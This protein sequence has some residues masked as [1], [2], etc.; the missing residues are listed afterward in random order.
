MMLASRMGV[1]PVDA[2]QGSARHGLTRHG[3]VRQGMARA[4]LSTELLRGLPAGFFGIQLWRG[5]AWLGTGRCG[6]VK[7][8]M[9]WLGEAW[10]GEGQTMARSFYGG[11][12]PPFGGYGAARQCKARQ[13]G[14][15]PGNA[16][17][18]KG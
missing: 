8:G 3:T 16:W 15:R 13:G 18:G 2:R 7:P 4:D 6:R 9:A 1:S 10:Q 11:S 14:A 12:L 5:L 17:L